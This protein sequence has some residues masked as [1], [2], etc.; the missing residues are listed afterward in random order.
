MQAESTTHYIAV[1]MITKQQIPFHNLKINDG[2]LILYDK[3]LSLP[4]Y[5]LYINYVTYHRLMAVTD[6]LNDKL[7]NRRV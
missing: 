7:R 6:G 3:D 1:M 5:M 4:I 2:D